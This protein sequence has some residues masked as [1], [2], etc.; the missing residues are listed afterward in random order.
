MFPQLPTL[1]SL[2]DPPKLQKRSASLNIFGGSDIFGGGSFPDIGGYGIGDPFGIFGGGGG[3]DGGFPGGFGDIS[4]G[5]GFIGG[6]IGGGGILG[7]GGGLGVGQWP[8]LN[9]IEYGGVYIGG[10]GGSS[11][12]GGS[13][14]AVNVGVGTSL[15]G[16]LGMLTGGFDWGRLAAFLLGLLLIAGGLYLLKP[17]QEVV[18][19]AVKKGAVALA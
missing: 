7:G 6:G 3:N 13:G 18:N 4:I 19:G 10:G 5:G 1:P 15:A 2:S 9:P 17:V 8:P 14:K 11:G 16:P 12:G